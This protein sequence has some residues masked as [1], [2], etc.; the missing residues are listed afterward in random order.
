MRHE[1]VIRGEAD[2]N[3]LPRAARANDAER[4]AATG[5]A[6]AVATQAD[7]QFELPPTFG[8]RSDRRMAMRAE[9]AWS[10]G[11]PAHNNSNLPGLGSVD[12]SPA[13][14]FA[15]HALLLDLR[16]GDRIEVLSSGDA[17]VAAFG[18][19][20]G[21]LTSDGEGGLAAQLLDSCELVRLTHA[22]VPVD[23]ALNGIDSA[24][25]LTRG[26]LMPLADDAGAL[27]YV[28]CVLNWKQVLDR[29]ASARLRREFGSA[30]L[31]LPREFGAFPGFDR[32]N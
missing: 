22:T 27:G 16:R 1:S 2:G 10:A 19:H 23:A 9:A 25:L 24:C 6:S 3:G 18:I 32:G 17:V 31:G 29:E 4:A 13:S 15:R 5:A 30:L 28:H 20:P 8:G 12:T 7:V 14:E 11:S 26:V 21:P